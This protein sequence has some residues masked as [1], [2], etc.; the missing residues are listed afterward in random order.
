[1]AKDPNFDLQREI[2]DCVRYLI[3][4]KEH[5]DAAGRS[6]YDESG[7]SNFLG[8]LETTESVLDKAVKQL[9]RITTQFEFGKMDKFSNV[10]KSIHQACDQALNAWV[11]VHNIRRQVRLENTGKTRELSLQKSAVRLAYAMQNNIGKRSIRS[12]SEKIM[13]GAKLD[14]PTDSA[15]TLW[16][17][18][19]KAECKI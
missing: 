15:I 16:L 2:D 18:E 11:S 7:C 17:Q 8:Q 5:E 9:Q 3:S 19:F 4:R 10:E 6:F 12:V 13:L 14:L 1:M